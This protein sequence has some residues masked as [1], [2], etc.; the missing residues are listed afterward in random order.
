MVRLSDAL[1]A[2]RRDARR[3]EAGSA[4]GRARAATQTAMSAAAKAN[5]TAPP[6]ADQRVRDRIRN[7]LDTTLIVEAAA[8]TGK[9][10]VLVNRIVAALADGRAALGRLRP[11]APPR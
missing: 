2:V 5:G 8:G 4:P 10:T 1:R 9:T 6:I 7:D 3:T 11:G